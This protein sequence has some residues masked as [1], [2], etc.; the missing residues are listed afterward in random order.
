MISPLST[1]MGLA[2]LAIVLAAS[3][4]AQAVDD[5]KTTRTVPDEFVA[6]CADK[7]CRR[8]VVIDLRIGDGRHF[9]QSTDWM[10]PAVQPDMVTVINGEAVEAVPVFDGENFVEWRAPSGKADEVVVRVELSQW[11]D[12][13]IGMRARI[14]HNGPRTLK[15]SL[16]MMTLD[17]EQPR[18]TSSCPMPPMGGTTELW[19]EPIHTLI[20]ERATYENDDSGIC[21]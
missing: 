1:T 10:Q 3:P 14:T 6:W 19:S 9:R 2:V 15:L 17:D 4:D 21:R 18:Y 7:P 12:E 13:S 20:I 16:S 5:I 8:N 11:P